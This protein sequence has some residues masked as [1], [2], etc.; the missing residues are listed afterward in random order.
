MQIKNERPP[1]WAR[2]K[3]VFDFDD[4]KTVFTYGDTLYNPSGGN[5]SNDVVLH[6]SVHSRQ[7]AAL[8]HWYWSGA[9]AWWNRYIKDP[10]FRV[11]Q[12]I[13]AYQMQYQ[14]LLQSGMNRE[15]LAKRLSDMAY[16]MSSKMYGNIIGY[17][18]A[19]RRIRLST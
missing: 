3:K 15:A 6:E 13:E 1:I 17:A 9:R 8:N 4:K 5:L 16:S 12:E 7:Q 11:E 18:E 2:A 19:I 14:F 10:Q